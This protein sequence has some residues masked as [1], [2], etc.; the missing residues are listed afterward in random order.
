MT[1][2]IPDDPDFIADALA[3]LHAAGWSIGET[4]FV[5]LERGG[6][7]HVVIGANGE[8][9]IGAEGKTAAEA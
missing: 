3:Q 5:D 9:L 8:N 1:N 6:I 7:V 2:H 4:A